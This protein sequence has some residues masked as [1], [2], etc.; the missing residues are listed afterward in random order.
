M[1]L[2]LATP[3]RWIV[4]GFGAAKIPYAR[5]AVALLYSVVLCVFGFELIE[6]LSYTL[7]NVIEGM[8]EPRIYFPAHYSSLL[9]GACIVPILWGILYGATALY[10]NSVDGMPEPILL[11]KVLILSLS[12]ALVALPIFSVL[13]ASGSGAMSMVGMLLYGSPFVLFV[14]YFLFWR[15]HTKRLPE[16]NEATSLNALFFTATKIALW[17]SAALFAFI[18]ILFLI[19]VLTLN[20]VGR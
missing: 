4:T 13:S 3:L 7:R 18:F 5:N 17:L 20:I 10:R 15:F 12:S 19:A 8:F 9:A 1:P 16:I 11:D 14:H 6:N 2:A